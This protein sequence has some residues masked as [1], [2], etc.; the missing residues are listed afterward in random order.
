MEQ[1]IELD[2]P[3][4]R[5]R[6]WRAEERVPEV[7]KAF[8]V[9]LNSG[10]ICKLRTTRYL[11]HPILQ[12]GEKAKMQPAAKVHMPLKTCVEKII[13]YR[14]PIGPSLRYYLGII[15]VA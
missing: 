1:K 8:A 2:I 13:C 3:Q 11:P 10:R 14:G 9:I 12:W 15:T 7:E 4:G 6:I 5:S